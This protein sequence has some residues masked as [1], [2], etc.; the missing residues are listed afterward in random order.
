MSLDLISAL[1]I[2]LNFYCEYIKVEICWLKKLYSE[3]WW[4][5]ASVKYCVLTVKTCLTAYHIMYKIVLK[6]QWHEEKGV[7]EYLWMN[8]IEQRNYEVFTEKNVEA[9]SF[10]DAAGKTLVLKIAIWQSY[11]TVITAWQSSSV[12]DNNNAHSFLIHRPEARAR[13]WP[14]PGK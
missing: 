3:Q 4:N 2:W 5:L 7:S 14:G 10:L 13:W 1:C 12:F 11:Q 8:D 9:L 6:K